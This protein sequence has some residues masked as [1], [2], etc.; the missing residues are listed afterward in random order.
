MPCSSV[1][2]VTAEPNDVVKE[3]ETLIHCLEQDSTST[4][5][6]PDK[7]MLAACR[8]RGRVLA[9]AMHIYLMPISTN[10][11]EMGLKPK[12]SDEEEDG[13]SSLVMMLDDKAKVLPLLT[14]T[15]PNLPLSALV[16]AVQ[17]GERAIGL[18]PK[19]TAVKTQ[20]INEYSKLLRV[21]P[22]AKFDDFEKLA[23]E[24][25]ED[26]APLTLTRVTLL[27]RAYELS[28]QKKEDSV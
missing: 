26:D 28:E 7:E 14:Q 10:L 19:A 5:E 3:L 22:E 27:T 17:E 1:N 23:Q 11:C 15:S 4:P 16:K 21:V 18:L 8:N 20:W 2:T 12:L 24:A 25:F 6:P 9:E 13:L